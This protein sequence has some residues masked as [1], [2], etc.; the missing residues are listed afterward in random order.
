MNR[1]YAN[2]R[3]VNVAA[4]P[5]LSTIGQPMVHPGRLSQRPSFGVTDPHDLI[6]MNDIEMRGQEN[7]GLLSIYQFD[8][9]KPP[10]CTVVSDHLIRSK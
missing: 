1:R 7:H 5:L 2:P 4:N 3:I 8:Q 6:E 9:A 10:K